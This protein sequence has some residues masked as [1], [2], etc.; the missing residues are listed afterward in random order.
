[1][2]AKRNYKD[3]VFCRLFSDEDKLRELYSA[4]SGK[5]YTK[6][7]KVEIVTLENSIFRLGCRGT[8][9]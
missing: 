6:E 9:K 5:E 4:L 1:M 2:E 7:T 3:S 8:Y